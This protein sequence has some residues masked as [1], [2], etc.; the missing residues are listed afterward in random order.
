[1]IFLPSMRA[2]SAQPLSISLF[3][4]LLCIFTASLDAT[5]VE[6]GT[7]NARWNTVSSKFKSQPRSSLSDSDVLKQLGFT[8]DTPN[9]TLSNLVKATASY[10]LFDKASLRFSSEGLAFVRY[11][12][13]HLKNN[14][15]GI[16]II[17]AQ[18]E[19]IDI[20]AAHI[21]ALSATLH[22]SG[23][24]KSYISITSAPIQ[25]TIVILEAGHAS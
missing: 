8:L 4:A 6:Q 9:S 13:S 15:T 25:G 1:M 14:Q 7:V 23:Q 5:G 10:Q 18:D 2:T 11:Y 3:L 24:R 22:G 21:A 12:S 17:I 19:N 20:T 16:R